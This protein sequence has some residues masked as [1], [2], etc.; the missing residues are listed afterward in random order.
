MQISTRHFS[1]PILITLLAVLLFS[2]CSRREFEQR[3]EGHWER[4]QVENIDPTYTEV[5]IMSGNTTT[6]NRHSV[7]NPSQVTT[8]DQGFYVVERKGIKMYVRLSA[9]RNSTLN[10]SWEIINLTDNLL[11][12]LIEVPGGIFLKEFVR[13]G[14]L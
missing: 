4:I 10:N 8:I 7:A 3:I 1:Q 14:G 12:I 11:V 2:S 5:W 13:K 9:F 6:I